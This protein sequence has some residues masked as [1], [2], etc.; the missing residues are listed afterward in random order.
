[1][2]TDEYEERLSKLKRE[3][4]ETQLVS[5][6]LQSMFFNTLGKHHLNCAASSD[7]REIAHIHV[8]IAIMMKQT[9]DKYE[10]LLNQYR[11]RSN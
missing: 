2:P 3:H 6:K 9:S 4:R 5:W 8:E 7:D 11:Q 1:M 10:C